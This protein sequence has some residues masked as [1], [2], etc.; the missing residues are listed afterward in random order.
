MK[1]LVIIPT[2]N[3]RENIED[4]ARQITIVNPQF[5]VLVVDD[6]SSDGTGTIVQSLGEQNCRISLLSRPSK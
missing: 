1:T 4:V 2:D 5:H 3:E 6:N